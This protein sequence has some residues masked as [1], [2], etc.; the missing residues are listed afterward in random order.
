MGRR[1]GKYGVETGYQGACNFYYAGLHITWDMGYNMGF[2]N[3]FAFK[4]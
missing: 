2:T 3:A 4:L 1:I